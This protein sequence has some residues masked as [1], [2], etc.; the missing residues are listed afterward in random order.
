LILDPHTGLPLASFAKSRDDA[1]WLQQFLENSGLRV[2]P[3]TRLEQG[4]EAARRILVSSRLSEEVI[5]RD[6]TKKKEA[7]HVQESG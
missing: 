3:G 4:L 1:D 7:E 6:M 5:Y 2:L